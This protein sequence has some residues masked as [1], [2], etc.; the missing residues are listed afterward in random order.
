MH[1]HMKHYFTA[2]YYATKG[3]TIKCHNLDIPVKI[4]KTGKLQ[5][6]AHVIFNNETD[7]NYFFLNIKSNAEFSDRLIF[8]VKQEQ[9]NDTRK[10]QTTTK[11]TASR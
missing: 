4:L 6:Y 11:R 7:K 9:K 8:E 3:I 1:P 5:P 10:L 2:M